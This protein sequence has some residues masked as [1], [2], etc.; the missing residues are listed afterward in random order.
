[1]AS[2]TA[3]SRTSTLLGKFFSSRGMDFLH[4][5]MGWHF[6]IFLFRPKEIEDSLGFALPAQSAPGDT[7]PWGN[8]PGSLC[9]LHTAFTQKVHGHNQVCSSVPQ[10]EIFRIFLPLVFY[11]KSILTKCWVSKTRILQNFRGSEF[12]F[13]VH[14]SSYR[15]IKFTKTKS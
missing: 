3:C 4:F 6:S 9:Y 15:V 1:M 14:F 8:L 7:R 13:L 2:A 12:W 10:C 5:P 11:V